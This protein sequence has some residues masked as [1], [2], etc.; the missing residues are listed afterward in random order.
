MDGDC[1]RRDEPGPRLLAVACLSCVVAFLAGWLTYSL[2]LPNELAYGLML[3]GLGVV[4]AEAPF[5]P[6]AVA[7]VTLALA[8]WSIRHQSNRIGPPT[9]TALS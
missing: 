8:I 5:I 2:D 3:L 1:P 6:V 7:A 9:T 4:F